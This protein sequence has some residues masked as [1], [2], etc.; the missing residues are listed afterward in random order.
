MFALGRGENV[1]SLYCTLLRNEC[2]QIDDT[3]SEWDLYNSSPSTVSPSVEKDEC[4]HLPAHNANKAKRITCKAIT[5]IDSCA[6]ECTWNWNVAENCG[7]SGTASN[8]N[9]DYNSE[10]IQAC[11]DACQ[12][13]PLCTVFVWKESTM[14]E[15]RKYCNS[16]VVSG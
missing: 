7:C 6:G 16:E 2:A 13:N 3:E 1:K 10:T 8:L 15:L 4:T 5:S 12:G 11:S 9:H 14:C